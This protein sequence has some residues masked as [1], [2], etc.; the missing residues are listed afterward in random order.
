MYIYVLVRVCVCVC[1]HVY[2]ITL[3]FRGSEFLPIP[4]F[5]LFAEKFSPAVGLRAKSAKVLNFS[6]NKFREI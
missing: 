6:L 5:E 4:D 1:V 2:R 3:K